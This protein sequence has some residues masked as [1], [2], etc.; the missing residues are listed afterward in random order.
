MRNTRG[1]SFGS[2]HNQRDHAY[3]QKLADVE[4]KRCF[5]PAERDAAAEYAVLEGNAY[6]G[7]L[8][9]A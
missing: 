2:D 5:S 6:I 9:I 8:T 4:I 3:N 7:S 1:K